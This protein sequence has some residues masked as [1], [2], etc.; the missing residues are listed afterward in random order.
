MV[1]KNYLV[2]I[3]NNKLSIDGEREV[4]C[5]DILNI[6]NSYEKIILPLLVENYYEDKIDIFVLG[7]IDPMRAQQVIDLNASL[8]RV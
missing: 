6:K 3:G 8:I 5:E 7:D 4:V 2:K 1:Y